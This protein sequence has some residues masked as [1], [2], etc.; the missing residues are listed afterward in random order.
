MEEVVK[1]VVPLIIEE[2]GSYADAG[3]PE[4]PIKADTGVVPVEKLDEVFSNKTVA[5]IMGKLRNRQNPVLM[6]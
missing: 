5:D 4:P 6:E 1:E 3:L 2:Y